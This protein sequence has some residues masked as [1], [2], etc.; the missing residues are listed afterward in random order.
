MMSPIGTDFHSK[1]TDAPRRI[2]VGLP[3]QRRLRAGIVLEFRAAWGFRLG[4]RARQASYRPDE[5]G[6]DQ[7]RTSRFCS[8]ASANLTP[9][10]LPSVT[11]LVTIKSCDGFSA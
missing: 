2:F 6:L 1:R 8:P 11:I 4:A 7:R 3:L 10:A 9:K 5:L